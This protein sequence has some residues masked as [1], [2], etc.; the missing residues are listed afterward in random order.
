M[1]FN[2]SSLS[3]NYLAQPDYDDSGMRDITTKVEPYR[4]YF[5]LVEKNDVLMEGLPA[6]RRNAS[7]YLP[8]F[9]DTSSR[10]YDV[11]LQE[12]ALDNTYTA[13]IRDSAGRIFTKEIASSDEVPSYFDEWRKDVDRKETSLDR[14]SHRVLIDMLQYGIAYVNV[15]APRVQGTGAMPWITN[16][17]A[18]Q[19]FRLTYTSE[20]GIDILQRFVWR[21]S[22]NEIRD[23]RM[24][25]GRAVLYIHTRQLRDGESQRGNFVITAQAVTDF[26][27][28]PIFPIYAERHS[29]FFGTPP[30]RFLADKSLDVTR[31]DTLINLQFNYTLNP[32][33]HLKGDGLGKNTEGKEIDVSID[34]AMITDAETEATWVQ[35]DDKMVRAAMDRVASLRREMQDFTINFIGRKPTALTATEVEADNAKERTR[36]RNIVENLQHGF[37]NVMR[38]VSDIVRQDWPDNGIS[39]NQELEVAAATKDHIDTLITMFDKNLITKEVFLQ[40]AKRANFFEDTFD[41]ETM[42]TQLEKEAEERRAVARDSN[43]NAPN[44]I[45]SPAATAATPTPDEEQEQ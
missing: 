31:R 39:F 17:K 36:L 26:D 44:T 23:Y 5:D 3:N 35:A 10:K 24:E 16:I 32:F 28:I 2:L 18:T 37:N 14:F 11:L 42:L 38:F 12:I 45:P 27:M 7:K 9:I 1:A 8:T 40:Q 20:D 25:E 43:A 34:L 33:L 29:F 6:I 22:N 19:L 15:D 4:D 21:V 41:I 30:L 13:A